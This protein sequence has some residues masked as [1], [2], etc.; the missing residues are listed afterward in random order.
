MVSTYPTT[1]PSVIGQ[2]ID[3]DYDLQWD[4]GFGV[5]VKSVPLLT[6]AD[7]ASGKQPTRPGKRKKRPAKKKPVKRSKPRPTK[8]TSKRKQNH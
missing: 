1:M 4:D 8:R 6:F 5:N 3:T 2:S 7:V